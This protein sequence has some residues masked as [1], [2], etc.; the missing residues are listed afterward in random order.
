[1]DKKEL[2]SSLKKFKSKIKDKYSI[3]ELIL[4]G[5]RANGRWKKESDVDLLVIGNFK[6][7]TNLRRSPPLYLEW[8]IDLPVD[9]ICYTPGEFNSLIKK[10]SIAKEAKESGIII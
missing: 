7:K 1:M 4:F 3:K 5:S 10:A 2:I 9:F 8:N 6:E